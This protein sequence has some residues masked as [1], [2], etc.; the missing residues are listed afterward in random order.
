[1]KWGLD[2]IGPLK[3][4]RRLTW[5]FLFLVTIDYATKWV[6]AKALITNIIIVIV[7]FMYGYIL[8]RF[9]CPLTTCTNQEVPFIN[10]TIKHL[11]KQFILKHVSSTTYCPQGY[12]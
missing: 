7:R 2:F 5:I 12:G 8:T 4:T 1:M 3:A 6:E 11:T 9:G 10:D